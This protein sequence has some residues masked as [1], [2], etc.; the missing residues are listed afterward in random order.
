MSGWIFVLPRLSHGYNCFFLVFF[1]FI[2]SLSCCHSGWS[3][4]TSAAPQ[5]NPLTCSHVCHNK[6]GSAGCEQGAEEEGFNSGLPAGVCSTQTSC[7][8]PLQSTW[9][10]RSHYSKKNIYENQHIEINRFF[11]HN[12]IIKKWLRIRAEQHLSVRIWPCFTFRWRVEQLQC[13]DKRFYLASQGH[14]VWKIIMMLRLADEHFQHNIINLCRA[15]SSYFSY[16]L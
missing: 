7:C 1:W 6:Q 15:E 4:N 8:R 5:E 11:T 9:T 3:R 2:H 16:P 12:S 10:R 13:T 14:C